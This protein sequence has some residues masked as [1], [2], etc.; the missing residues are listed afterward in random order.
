MAPV[1]S[2]DGSLVWDKK[3]ITLIP[4]SLICVNTGD[5]RHVP[6]GNTETTNTEHGY[7]ALTRTCVDSALAM[8]ML[9]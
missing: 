9:P 8:W 5:G 6:D 2:R 7:L 1:R 3:Q 4:I